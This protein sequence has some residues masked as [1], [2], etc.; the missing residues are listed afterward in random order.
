MFLKVILLITDVKK[1]SFKDTIPPAFKTIQ[2]WSGLVTQF[3]KAS[4]TAYFTR[5]CG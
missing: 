5:T 4:G 1:L 2:L 3:Y